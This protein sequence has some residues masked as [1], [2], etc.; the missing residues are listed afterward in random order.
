M[1]GFES[2]GGDGL[3]IH[4]NIF[5]NNFVTQNGVIYIN[6]GNFK[7]TGSKYY[8][9]AGISGG[10][11]N[12][13]DSKGAVIENSIFVNNYAVQGGTIYIQ[14][15]TNLEIKKCNFKGSQ[16]IMKGGTIMVTRSALSKGLTY[17]LKIDQI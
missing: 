5:E 4:N 8:Y 11:I 1:I 17:L 10:A 6:K 7:D 16:A 3:L 15:S 12:L 9:N 2:S 13:K 14:D